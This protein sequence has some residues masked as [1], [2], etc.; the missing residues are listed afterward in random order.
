MISIFRKK[1]NRLTREQLIEKYKIPK[2][3]NNN[4]TGEF[5]KK[6]FRIKLWFN[7]QW[8][9]I[10]DNMIAFMNIIKDIVR[11]IVNS[12]IGCYRI[13]RVFLNAIGYIV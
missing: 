5:R 6:I 9:D 2:R 13:I 12:I 10:K 7:E 8:M 1:R 3:E 11:S 4:F